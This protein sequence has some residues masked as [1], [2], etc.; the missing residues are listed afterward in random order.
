MPDPWVSLPTEFYG[1]CLRRGHHHLLDN[2]SPTLRFTITKSKRDVVTA[3]RE[4]CVCI[5]TPEGGHAERAGHVGQLAG[6]HPLPNMASIAAAG[7][8]GFRIVPC[9][10]QLA[11]ITVAFVPEF[12]PTTPFARAPSPRPTGPMLSVL[13]TTSSCG[14]QCVPPRVFRTVCALSLEVKRPHCI[15]KQR[16]ERQWRH[17]LL[18]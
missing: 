4:V 10:S 2:N 5:T 1:V 15:K 18:Y 13:I 17:V 11:R 12:G 16:R 8:E 9:A 6:F 14:F 3:L 7:R